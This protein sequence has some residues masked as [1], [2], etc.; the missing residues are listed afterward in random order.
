MSLRLK[1]AAEEDLIAITDFI[2]RDS[3]STAAEY[4]EKLLDR[5]VAIAENPTIYRV[6][7]EWGDGLRAVPFGGYLIVYDFDGSDVE[8]IRILSAKRDIRTIL[9]DE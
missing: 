8:I 5:C 3:P 1:A 2:G 7:S 6:R 4:I 9:E